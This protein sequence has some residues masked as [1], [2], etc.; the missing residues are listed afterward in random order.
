MISVTCYGTKQ[1]WLVAYIYKEPTLP[2]LGCYIIN[3]FF[4]NLLKQKKKDS[5]LIKHNSN[6]MGYVNTI[7]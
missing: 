6:N 5:Y 2:I 4:V 1:Q 7:R 3:F